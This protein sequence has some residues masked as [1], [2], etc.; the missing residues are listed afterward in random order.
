MK[1]ALR[2][3]GKAIGID[4]LSGLAAFP[5]YADRDQVGDWEEGEL[6]ALAGNAFAFR[7]LAS[8]RQLSLTPSGRLESR[9]AGW[10]GVWEMFFATQQPDG[11][12]ILYRVTSAG[13]LVPVVLT[14]EDRS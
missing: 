10:V 3:N 9:Y 12:A 11:I 5:I 7:F 1:V 4:P 2:L 8:N 13:L 14:I 6:T